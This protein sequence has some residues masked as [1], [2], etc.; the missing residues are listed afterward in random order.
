VRF[1]VNA[2]P[3]DGA[4]NRELV[5][6]LS[7]IL[8]VPASRLSIVAGERSRDKDVLI[9]SELTESQILER[10]GIEQGG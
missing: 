10:M 8:R 9:D 5:K 7:R 2:P 3:V 6:S 4:A 1:G